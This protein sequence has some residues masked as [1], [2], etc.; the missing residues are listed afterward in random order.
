MD[1]FTTRKDL[2]NL[3]TFNKSLN[4]KLL[5]NYHGG[6]AKINFV[7]RVNADIMVKQVRQDKP[8]F[9]QS[10]EIP[11]NIRHLK[12]KKNKKLSSKFGMGICFQ[13][14]Q[15]KHKLTEICPAKEEKNGIK[16]KCQKC[17]KEGHL[18]KVCQYLCNKCGQDHKIDD[19]CPAKGKNCK[20]C[21]KKNHFESVCSKK[22]KA[23][24]NQNKTKN[25]MGRNVMHVVAAENEM[26]PMPFYKQQKIELPS[27]LKTT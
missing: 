13:C 16:V 9:V 25:S 14:G 12:K 21:N 18:E 6:H 24:C 27:I 2:K 20:Y 7:D 10:P 15:P 8:Q 19:L 3:R 5:N 1:S 26:Y 11:I 23:Q 4:K 17:F 22:I